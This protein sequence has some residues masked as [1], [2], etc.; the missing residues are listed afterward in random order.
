[1]LMQQQKMFLFDDDE[2]SEADGD[3]DGDVL[4]IRHEFSGPEGSKVGQIPL[5]WVFSMFLLCDINNVFY[6]VFAYTLLP[7]LLCCFIRFG[8]MFFGFFFMRLL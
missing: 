3:D 2:D 6:F 8:F 5:L 1:M 7:F 4:K